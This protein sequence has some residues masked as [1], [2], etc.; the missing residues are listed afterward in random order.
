MY[1]DGNWTKARFQS[2]IKSA[3][4][5]ATLKWPPKFN[6]KKQARKERGIYLCAGYNRDE[7]LVP[8]SLPPPDGK[9]RRID[10][11]IVDHI[12][13]VVPP[14]GI[15]TWD[16]VIDRMFCNTDGLQLL[17]H[18]CHTNKTFDERLIRNE[19]FGRDD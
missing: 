17:C 7:H 16:E 12:I 1:N 9:K 13:P 15:R 3:L 19:R 4:R 2:F 14:E 6:V 18:E 8:A 11:A 5:A 10:N